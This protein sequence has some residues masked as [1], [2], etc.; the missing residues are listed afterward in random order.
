MQS[1]GNFSPL[2]DTLYSYFRSISRQNVLSIW[3][4]FFF[5]KRISTIILNLNDGL[6]FNVRSL[7]NLF[8]NLVWNDDLTKNINTKYVVLD[9][10]KFF[11]IALLF[12]SFGWDSAFWLWLS[13]TLRN[14]ELNQ[15]N[16]WKLVRPN[17]QIKVK[18]V[19]ISNLDLSL[20]YTLKTQALYQ[21]HG[22]KADQ[23]WITIECHVRGRCWS[24]Y[25]NSGFIPFLTPLCF[26]LN[27]S[28]PNGNDI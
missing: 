28:V 15:M 26:N 23:T 20:V 19:F 21:I 25:T 17:S 14:R 6:C 9:K 1:L 12:I 16:M 11:H 10:K 7:R 2:F 3:W 27:R 18:R 5:V 22:L 8:S 13:K 4:D 24:M